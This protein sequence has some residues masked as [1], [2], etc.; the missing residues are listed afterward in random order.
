MIIINFE[1]TTY[2]KKSVLQFEKRTE[3]RKERKEKEKSSFAILKRHSV[4][5]TKLYYD[6]VSLRDYHS[7]MNY[8]YDL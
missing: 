8:L 7:C 1:K 3:K 4:F 6:H 5:M 2:E